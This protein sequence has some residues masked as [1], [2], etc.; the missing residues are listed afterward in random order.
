LQGEQHPHTYGGQHNEN[1][2][3]FAQKL[4]GV[5]QVTS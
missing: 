5:V 3:Y 2:N 4:H 1:S